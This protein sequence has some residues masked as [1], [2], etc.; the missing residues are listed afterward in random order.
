MNDWFATEGS[1]SPLRVTWVPADEAFTFAL[2]SA[3]MRPR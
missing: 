1:P 3:S 2:Y